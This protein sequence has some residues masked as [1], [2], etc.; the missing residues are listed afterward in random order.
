MSYKPVFIFENN[1]RCTNGQAFATKEEARLS[2]AARF[3][4]WTMPLDYDVESSNEPVNYRYENG[5]DISIEIQ[6]LGDAYQAE[7]N[8]T[9]ESI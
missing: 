1:E 3:Q 9:K 8:L 2:A 4:R 7:D 5:Q 6:Q